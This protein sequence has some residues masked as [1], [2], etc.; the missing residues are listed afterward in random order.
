MAPTTFKEG[1]TTWSTELCA[2]RERACNRHLQAS[3]PVE[4]WFVHAER[5]SEERRCRGAGQ[6]AYV[7]ALEDGATGL[8]G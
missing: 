4:S 5:C 3:I 8:E 2:C 6:N 7:R 1:S